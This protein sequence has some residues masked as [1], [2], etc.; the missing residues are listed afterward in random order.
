MKLGTRIQVGKLN[1]T[2]KP[3]HS[4][5]FPGHCLEWKRH[6]MGDKNIS[7]AEGGEDEVYITRTHG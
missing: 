7:R 3:G 1:L 6:F 5:L 4:I 2:R